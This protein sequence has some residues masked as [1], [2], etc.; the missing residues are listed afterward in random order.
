MHRKPFPLQITDLT[1][2]RAIQLVAITQRPEN[3]SETDGF[4]LIADPCQVCPEFVDLQV[5]LHNVILPGNYFLQD[6]PPL[7][8][9]SVLL[10]QAA[11]SGG[12]RIDFNSELINA[13]L[14]LADEPFVDIDQ[15][16]LLLNKLVIFF[17]LRN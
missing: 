3:R 16:S 5:I 12:F 9:S 2:I 1:S 7:T 13:I 15:Q 6:N 4:V 10:L 11:N 14:F 8:I 17:N